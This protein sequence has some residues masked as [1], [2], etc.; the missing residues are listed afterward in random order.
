MCAVLTVYCCSGKAE[1]Y[2][3]NGLCFDLSVDSNVHV[4]RNSADEQES[5]C[6]SEQELKVTNTP[7]LGAIFSSFDSVP[8]ISVGFALVAEFGC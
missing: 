6:L 1:A 8:S 3:N 5:C 7:S 2:H 4:V